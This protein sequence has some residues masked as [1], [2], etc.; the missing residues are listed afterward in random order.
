MKFDTICLYLLVVERKPRSRGHSLDPRT[1]PFH[2]EV[3]R[4]TKIY[5]PKATIDVENK[6]QM[7]SVNIFFFHF[8]C[9]CP[10]DFQTALFF[11]LEK[12]LFFHGKIDWIFAIFFSIFS[13]LW[14][15]IQK[16]WVSKILKKVPWSQNK[17]DEG[18]WKFLRSN[19]V[20]LKWNGS[21]EILWLFTF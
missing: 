21:L 14:N 15:E 11:S 7:K 12:M 5:L 13:I 16:N 6:N 20:K 1:W 10:T 4:S 3:L 17:T 18:R 9:F 8:Q 19:N 2:Q